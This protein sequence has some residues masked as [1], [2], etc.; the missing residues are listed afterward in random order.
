MF[1]NVAVPFLFP[2]PLLMVV[3]L[4]PVVGVETI[5]LRSRLNVT[6]REVLVANILSTLL[7]I[8]LAYISILGFNTVLTWSAGPWWTMDM[9]HVTMDDFNAWWILGSAMLVVLAPCFLLSVYLEGHYLRSRSA[10]RVGRPFWYSMLRAHCYSY[11]VLLF[12][13]CLWIAIRLR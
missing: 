12:L 11:L 4:I 5:T 13:E 9:A 1:G 6:Y 8:P 2:Q 3:A 10:A 7:G